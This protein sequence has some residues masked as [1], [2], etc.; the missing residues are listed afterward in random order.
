[1]IVCLFCMFAP[2]AARLVPFG[3]GTLAAGLVVCRRLHR[4]LFY[5]RR[6]NS[7]ER[8]ARIISISTSRQIDAPASVPGV[9]IVDGVVGSS[10]LTDTFACRPMTLLFVLT[11]RYFRS[12]CW[13]L[14]EWIWSAR[15]LCVNNLVTVITRLNPV[16]RAWFE[17]WIVHLK[18]GSW[19]SSEKK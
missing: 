7:Y 17:N 10:S 14:R 4:R 12:S 8:I 6:W 19:L 13:N 5:R 1:M 11:A 9:K 16:N 2:N 3:E 18:T 15:Q